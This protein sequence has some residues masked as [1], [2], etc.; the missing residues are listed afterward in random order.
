MSRPDAFAAKRFK[1]KSAFAAFLVCD[2]EVDEH[3]DDDH[4]E[5]DDRG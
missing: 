4:H 5:D 1:R 3:V 2:D